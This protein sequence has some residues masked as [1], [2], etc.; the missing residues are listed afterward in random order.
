MLLFNNSNCVLQ[1]FGGLAKS[2]LAISFRWININQSH[3]KLKF[4]ISN[5]K[6][7]FNPR[8]FSFTDFKCL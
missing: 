8:S 2:R 6:S 1:Y 3:F 5:A 4:N 7:C